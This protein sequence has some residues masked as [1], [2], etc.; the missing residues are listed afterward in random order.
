MIKDLNDIE[1]GNGKI[2]IKKLKVMIQFQNK[3]LKIK[4]I[5]N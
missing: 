1:K 2:M 4:R 5:K 3:N